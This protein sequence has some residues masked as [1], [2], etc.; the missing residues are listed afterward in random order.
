[1]CRSSLNQTV[2]YRFPKTAFCSFCFCVHIPQ[3][4]Y[5]PLNNCLLLQVV[6][7]F[8]VNSVVLFNICLFSIWYT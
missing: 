3:V 6:V 8:G 7:Y 5:I 4:L 1:M 2:F